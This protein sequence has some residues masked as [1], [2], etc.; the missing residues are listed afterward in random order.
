MI[1]Q[2]CSDVLQM[3][4]TDVRDKQPHQQTSSPDDVVP[5]SQIRPYQDAHNF[6]QQDMEVFCRQ[7]AIPRRLHPPRPSTR[8]SSPPHRSNATRLRHVDTSPAARSARVQRRDEENDVNYA[9][10]LLDYMTDEPTQHNRQDTQRR[11]EVARQYT[12]NW[13]DSHE[14]PGY[15]DDPLPYDDHHNAGPSSSLQV[16]GVT[17]SLCLDD[18]EE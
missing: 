6:E 4:R 8:D 18:D 7:G 14:T 9:L 17:T 15:D 10:R 16:S 2:E 3:Q 5:Y 11:T 12:L 13:L 1:C